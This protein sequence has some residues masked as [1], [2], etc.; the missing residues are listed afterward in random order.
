MLEDEN[1]TLLRR[2]VQQGNWTEAERLA[3]VVHPNEHDANG[4][5]FL[6][7]QQKF[8]ELLEQAQTKK[9]LSVLRSELAPL[10]HSPERL[11][12][13]SRCLSGES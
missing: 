4:L 6:I 9:A 13:L 7:R 3:L 8:L 2:A 11:H 12:L 5:R 10:Q 1:V